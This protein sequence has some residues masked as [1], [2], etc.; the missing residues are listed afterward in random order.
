MPRKLEAGF[1][2]RYLISSVLM[3]STMKSDPA[4][5]LIRDNSCGVPVSAIATCMVGGK[6]EGR[7]RGEPAGTP[8][9]VPAS[10]DGDATALAAL[11]T[12]TLARN[13]RRLTG[14]CVCLRAIG[15][16]WL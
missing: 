3:T 2:G 5:P 7:G 13:L 1:A 4:T 8:V 9:C 11:A 10:A 15:T 6:A 14:G 12:A 16:S